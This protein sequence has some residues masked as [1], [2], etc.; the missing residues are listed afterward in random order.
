LNSVEKKLIN[1]P[2][3]K[4]TNSYLEYLID[5][6]LSLNTDIL[7]NGFRDFL[8]SDACNVDN[9]LKDKMICDFE[10]RDAICISSSHGLLAISDGIGISLSDG[11]SILDVMIYDLYQDGFINDVFSV[12][13]VVD[14]LFKDLYGEKTLLNSYMIFFYNKYKDNKKILKD[15]LDFEKVFKNL[16]EGNKL[17]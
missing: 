15:L 10:N 14:L 5:D 1:L 12:D 2:F 4:K 6:G 13:D 9:D 17:S 3:C 8:S 7:F 11:Y 16:L